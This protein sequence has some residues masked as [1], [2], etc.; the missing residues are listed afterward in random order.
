MYRIAICDDEPQ[1]RSVIRGLTEEI[2]LAEGQACEITE[3]AAPEELFEALRQAPGGCDLVLLDIMFPE[4]D[5]DG[6]ALARRL[7]EVKLGISIILISASPE[8][9]L[10]GYGVQAVQY[11]LKPLEPEKLRS[12]LLY[13]LHNH[14]SRRALTLP[15]KQGQLTVY[16]Q[17]ILYLESRGHSTFVHL[18]GGQAIPVSQKLSALERQLDSRCFCSCHKSFCVNL[19]HAVSLQRYRLTLRGGGGVPVSK[20]KFTFFRGVFVKFSSLSI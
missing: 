4:P 20:T 17:D 13:D 6:L 10:E 2:L 9:V 8:Y 12:A 15:S 14:F 1:A 3:Y 5:Q 18:L 7:R 16:Q 19:N 11:L